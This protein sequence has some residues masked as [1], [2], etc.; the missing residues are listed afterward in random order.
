MTRYKPKLLLSLLLA[1]AMVVTMLPSPALAAEA[2]DVPAITVSEEMPEETPSPEEEYELPIDETDEEIATPEEPEEEP[3]LPEETPSDGFVEEP[4]ATPTDIPEEDAAI[5][6]EFDADC[7]ELFIY[8]AGHSEPFTSPDD[9]PWADIRGSI[10]AAYIDDCEGLTIQSTAYWFA[11]CVNLEYV[12]INPPVGEIGYHTFYDCEALHDIVFL[13]EPDFPVL[14]QGAFET[15][16]P[17]EWKTDYDPRLNIIVMEDWML[18]NICA[19]DWHVDDCP[20]TACTGYGGGV[21]TYAATAGSTRAVGYCSY[22][23]KTCAY[24]EGYDQWTATVHCHRLWCSNCGY[25][26]AS[27]VLGESHVFSHYN[28]SYDRCSYCGYQT[29]CTHVT[30]CYHTSTYTSWSGCNW[31][32]YCRSC[33]VLVDSGVSH[34]SY[35]YGSWQYYSTSQHRRSYACSSCGSGSYE[36]SYHSTTTKYGQYSSTQHSVRSYCSTCSSYIGSTS[37]ASHSFSYGSWSNYSGTQHRRL[38]TCSVCGY[39]EYEY[40][41][42]SL[43]YGSWTSDSATRHKRTVSCATCG[44]SSYEYESHTLSP[45][46]WVS[47]S[48]TRH[49]RTLTCSCGYSIT[50]TADHSL[51]YS[52]WTPISETHHQRTGSCACGYSNTETGLHNDADGDGYCDDC[53]YLLT[54][55]SVTVPAS[56]TM[57]V[58]KYGEVYAASNAAIVNNSTGMVEVTGITVSTDNGWT[59]VPYGS[60]MAS[61]KVDSKLIGFSVNG[62]QS[63]SGGNTQMLT[64]SDGWLIPS[65][66]SLPLVY[67]AVVSALSQPVSEQV[68]T[69]VF[70]LEW[71]PK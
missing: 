70:V 57:T 2:D 6:W 12:E 30:V 31:Y 10:K 67:D 68:L 27:G 66:E 69:V 34:S 37:Y 50:E 65:S 21:S 13:Y 33:G 23:K 3:M 7:G 36:Y 39:S 41:S 49:Q 9:Q 28:S 1:L 8:C 46:D 16:H 71:A 15:H 26:Q 51:T 63:G 60:N 44:Y 45:G 17:L 11:G 19:Y 35:T 55:F 64:L 42:H 59:L 56:L 24:T 20:L 14:V 54:R 18:D 32:K 53:G 48:D 25:D 61:A 40:S 47:V 5:E 38:K 22:C 4:E 43:K 62:A 58:S 52:E 29:A